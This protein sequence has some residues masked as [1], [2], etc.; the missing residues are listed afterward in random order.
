MPLPFNRDGCYDG[1]DERMF[2]TLIIHMDKVTV[3]LHGHKFLTY[4]DL[5]V[6]V[7]DTAAHFHLATR[8]VSEFVYVGD[9]AWTLRV[10]A[11]PDRHADSQSPRYT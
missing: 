4:K 1:S 6:Q 9:I 2:E 7:A 11:R 10:R 8:V 5:S 3:Y